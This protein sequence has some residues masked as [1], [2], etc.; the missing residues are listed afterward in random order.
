MGQYSLIQ[1]TDATWNVARGCTKVD[2]DC[3][4]CYMYRD[5]FAGSRYNP[6][7]VVRTKGVFN[8]PLKY[9]ETVS[10]CWPG[11][12]LIFTSSLTDVFHPA[13]DS[14]RNEMWD[15]IRQC[16]HL[17]FQILTKRPERIL[18]HLP[19]F[20]DEIKDHVWLGTSIGSSSDEA[21][22][23]VK[24]LRN[25]RKI[26]ATLFLSVEPMHAEVNLRWRYMPP[27]EE[28][29]LEEIS[30]EMKRIVSQ[31]ELLM[32]FDWVIVGGESGNDTGKYRYRPCKLHWLSQ[33]V[34][35]CKEAG[36]PVFV[37]QLGTHLAKE[38]KMSDRHGGSIDEFPK[39]LQFREFPNR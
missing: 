37:K 38:R 11:K 30:G 12:P 20:W 2:K 31:H 35:D 9:K 26:A 29:R 10:S 3:L 8:F 36:V 32:N 25:L 5:S 19:E 18:Q 15:I 34:Q 39:N 21:L 17:I 13:I 28:R 1:W 33:M 22:Q 4:F 6:L 24:D 7:Q 14:Y 27:S 16:P 23:R